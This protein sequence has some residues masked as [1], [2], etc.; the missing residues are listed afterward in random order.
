MGVRELAGRLG[1]EEKPLL[2]FAADIIVV[3]QDD[4]LQRHQAIEV[5]IFRLV[6][7]AHGAAPELADDAV[8]P[9]LCRLFRHQKRVRCTRPCR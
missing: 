3:R 5:R 2:V 1:L 8:A 4:G 7:D 9:N 6:D